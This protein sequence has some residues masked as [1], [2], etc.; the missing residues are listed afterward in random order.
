MNIDKNIMEAPTQSFAAPKPITVRIGYAWPKALKNKAADVKASPA[1]DVWPFLRDRFGD[2]LDSIEKTTLKK[3]AA[4]SAFSYRLGR[5]RARHGAGV[6]PRFIELCESSDIVAFDISKFNPNVMFELGLAIASKGVSSG[7][8]FVFMETPS[9]GEISKI[10]GEV[11]SDLAGY[12]ITFYVRD[13]DGY[14]ICDPRGFSAALRAIVLDD[15]RS[16]GMVVPKGRE[17][18]ESSQ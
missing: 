9:C 4:P 17:V 3:P 16:R 10:L 14:K 13:E 6:L 8:V 5:M 15:A 2:V 1:D 11:P 18:E 12:F 7:R